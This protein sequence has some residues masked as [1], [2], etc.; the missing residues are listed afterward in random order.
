MDLEKQPLESGLDATGEMPVAEPQSFTF[1]EVLQIEAQAPAADAAEEQPRTAAKI[2]TEAPASDRVVYEYEQEFQRDGILH[3][4]RRAYRKHLRALGI[5]AVLTVMALLYECLPDR[6]L[7]AALSAAQH[8]VRHILFNDLLWVV[9]LLCVGDS[10]IKGARALFSS[11]PEPQSLLGL[12]VTATVL[13]QAVALLGL[14]AT[15]TPSPIQPAALFL[16]FFCIGTALLEIMELRR[17]SYAFDQISTQGEK[18]VLCTTTEEGC[19]AS[20]KT[21]FF[22]DFYRNGQKYSLRHR[23]IYWYFGGLLAIWL[24]FFLLYLGRVGVWD[25]LRCAYVSLMMATPTS[26]VI[27]FAFPQ[28]RLARALYQRD[29]MVLS[30]QTTEALAQAHNVVLSD[31]AVLDEGG[32]QV[33]DLRIYGNYPIDRAL[34]YM[35]SALAG[36]DCVM[37]RS[38]CRGISQIGHSRDCTVNDRAEGGICATV[39]GKVLVEFGTA[40]YFVTRG[41]N[42]GADATPTRPYAMGYLAIDSRIVATMRVN[43]ALR[44]DFRARLARCAQQNLAVT[45]RSTDPLLSEDVL[46]LLS[47]DKKRGAKLYLQKETAS[48]PT[49]ARLAAIASTTSDDE[50][51]LLDAVLCANDVYLSTKKHQFTATVFMIVSLFGMAALQNRCIDG[52]LHAAVLLPVLY[53]AVCNLAMGALLWLDEKKERK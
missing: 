28:F 21:S 17:E 19:Y 5:L 12:V 49:H 32:V 47:A 25:G 30:E 27:L 35:G 13:Y 53:Q 45:V 43:Y 20:A 22:S 41:Y 48:A 2:V 14:G 44:E 38:F 3:K 4:Y 36:E 16:L 50:L 8:P 39:D 10:F 31:R 11:R 9:G 6:L 34:Y 52:A 33:S 18:H 37:A 29:A 51:V 24:V 1:D 46:A 7:P 15:E 40:A 23:C 26:L 42:V